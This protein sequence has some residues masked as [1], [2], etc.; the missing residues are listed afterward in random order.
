M[1]CDPASEESVIRQLDT[2]W[3]GALTAKDL[4][5]AMAYYAQGAV[6]LTPGAPIITGV[7]QIRIWFAQRIAL[8]GYSASFVPTAIAVARSCDMAYE[9]GAYRAVVANASGAMV[10]TTGKH[11]VT[12]EKRGGSWKVTAESINP[13][14][15]PPR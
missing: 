10:I 5:G 2:A 11:L 6:L 13:D 7:D 12:W 9:L 4:D 8:P 3:S 15:P 1:T 14:H